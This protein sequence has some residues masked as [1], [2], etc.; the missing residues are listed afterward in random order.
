MEEGMRSIEWW[1]LIAGEEINN[2][3]V[4]VH[5]YLGKNYGGCHL[6]VVMIR[7]D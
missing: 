5:I 6:H 1:K 4:L 7:E 3:Q 2:Q